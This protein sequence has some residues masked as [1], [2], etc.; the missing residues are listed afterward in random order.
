MGTSHPLWRVLFLVWLWPV[1]GGTTQGVTQPAI[2]LFTAEEA[3]K[4]RLVE[5][6]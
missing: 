2:P 5:E 4:L 1:T 3:E 6:E